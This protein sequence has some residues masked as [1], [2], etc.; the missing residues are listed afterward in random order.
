MVNPC[1]VDAAGA[2]V[3]RE[4]DAAGA[5]VVWVVDTVGAVVVCVVDKG[6]VFILGELA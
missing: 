4:V 2:V 6:N 1:L 5:V 3:V